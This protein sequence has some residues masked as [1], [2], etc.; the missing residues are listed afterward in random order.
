MLE[1]GFFHADP[2]GGN[3]LALPNGKLCYLDF[4][5]VRRGLVDAEWRRWK[6]TWVGRRVSLPWRF[7]PKGILFDI[8]HH[9]CTRE[10]AL[11]RLW[12]LAWPGLVHL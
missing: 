9:V 5:M 3:L 6:G 7:D 1:N 2:H 8:F 4:G 10:G 11:D 12:C